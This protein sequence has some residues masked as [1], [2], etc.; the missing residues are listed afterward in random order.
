MTAS[1]TAPEVLT[2]SEAANRAD[3]C[4]ETLKK[5]IRENR[6]P[7]RH[8]YGRYIISRKKFDRWLHGPD[9][10]EIRDWLTD[11]TNASEVEALLSS[12]GYE[13][14]QGSEAA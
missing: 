2:V 9:V 14:G 13:R 4:G 7:G 1:K 8:L 11:G 10:S 3:I 12:L 6:I 5:G